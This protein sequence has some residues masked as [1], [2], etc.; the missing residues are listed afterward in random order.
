MIRLNFKISYALLFASKILKILIFYFSPWLYI[1]VA[2]HGRSTG[3]GGIIGSSPLSWE[4]WNLNFLCFFAKN[5]HIINH[6]LKIQ[7]K[8]VMQTIDTSYVAD[9]PCVLH[10]TMTESDIGGFTFLWI[11]RIMGV[12]FDLYTFNDNAYTSQINCFTIL[13]IA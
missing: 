2:L 1:H 9:Q 10:D 11:Q 6:D 5:L 8:I 4:S 13:W 7:K 3:G 12:C